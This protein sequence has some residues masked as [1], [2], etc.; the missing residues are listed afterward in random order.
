MASFI[1]RQEEDLDN[2]DFTSLNQVD[3]E[4]NT[5][6]ED[7]VQPTPTEDDLPEKYRGKSPKEIVR[8]H[9]E[10]EK[11]LGRQS[12][13]VG[14]LRKVVDDF[15][16][17]QSNTNAPQQVDTS[18][19]VDFF[20]EPERAVAKAIENHP[21]FK[22]ARELSAQMKQQAIVGQLKQTH[23]DFADIL[24]D[25]GFQDWVQASKVRTRLL[26]EADKN[27]DFDAADELLSNWKERKG[28]VAQA[29]ATQETERKRQLK[30]ASTGT[31]KGS[32]ET[33][34][35]KL[36]RRA[37]IIKL[38]QNDPDRYL[39]LADEITSAYAEGRVR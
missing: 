34:S 8:M 20:V 36:Y 2:P 16:K 11:L 31:A 22:Q 30:T 14:E 28:A 27:Y 1:E 29:Q 9:Q 13:E 37:D 24:Q 18:D 6:V 38:M 15:I 35:K 26:T 19:E 4:S 12:S 17:T 10:A 39:Q 7:A 25:T 21:E 3:E 32:G 33:P 5:E 23:P